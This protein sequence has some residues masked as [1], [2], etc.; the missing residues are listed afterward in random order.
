MTRETAPF[1]LVPRDEYIAKKSQLVGERLQQVEA[2]ER[3]IVKNPD[4]DED[5]WPSADGGWLDYSPADVGLMIEYK[6][7]DRPGR[8]D[9]V[10]LI[11]LIDVAAAASG[12]R[13]PVDS[14]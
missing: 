9:E 14:G 7:D 1:R 13:W 8:E 12:R 11:D 6:R 4:H 2:A 5:R 10:E 3:E